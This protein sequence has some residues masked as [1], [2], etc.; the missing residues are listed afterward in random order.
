MRYIMDIRK[1]NGKNLAKGRNLIATYYEGNKFKKEGF[2]PRYYVQI[3]LDSRDLKE[4]EVQKSLNLKRVFDKDGKPDNSIK[5]TE[6]QFNKIL[7]VAGENVYKGVTP[8][9]GVEYTQIGFKAD[10]MRPK[11]GKG[12]IP[13]TRSLAK[14]DFTIDEN[15]FGMQVDYKVAQKAAREAAAKVKAE[16]AMIEPEVEAEVDSPD[17]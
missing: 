9:K 10:L 13:D 5:L 7:E 4:G 17:F 16:P 15:T 3:E 12:L 6:G 14:G 8:N 2:A 11:D 1:E